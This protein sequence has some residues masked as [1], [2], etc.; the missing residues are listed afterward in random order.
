MISFAKS[1]LR[2]GLYIVR[3]KEFSII[4]CMCITY[5]W[6]KA[7]HIHNRQAILSS[8]RVLHKDYY[9]KG[10]VEKNSGRGSQ[11]AWHQEEMIGGKPPVIK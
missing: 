2:E 8:E 11:G 10:L 4:C 6:R 5:I 3:K 1:V 7:K 9:R